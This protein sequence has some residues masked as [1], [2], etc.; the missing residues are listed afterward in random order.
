[1]VRFALCCDEIR[2]EENTAD[3]HDER[4]DRDRNDTNGIT[5]RNTVHD[6][7]EKRLTKRIDAQNKCPNESCVNRETSQM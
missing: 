1:M 5:R 3:E 2:I 4:T 6:K 7:R